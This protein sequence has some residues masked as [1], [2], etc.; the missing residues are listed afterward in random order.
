MQ[1]R[2]EVASRLSERLWMEDE[3]VASKWWVSF[4]GRKFMG[5]AL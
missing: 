2:Q 5:R 3:N 4:R 1:L